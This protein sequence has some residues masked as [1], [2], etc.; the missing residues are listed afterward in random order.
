VIAGIALGPSLL[1]R[2]WPEA[3]AAPLPNDVAPFTF[4]G[5]RTQ[6]GLLQ[7]V[8][9]WLICAVIVVVATAGKFGGTFAAA[10]FTGLSP[11]SSASLG[12]LMNTRGL[13]GL[14]VLNVGL[15][16]GVMTPKLFAMM[17]LMT[18][19][20]TLATSPLLAWLVPTPA[21]EAVTKPGGESLM[22]PTRTDV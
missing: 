22:D 2:L 11:R 14:I 19:A 9:D 21:P 8:E 18:L 13:M 17:V 3:S 1:G 20:T 5:L 16:L 15:D 6:I 12:V 7:G 4:T 10:R